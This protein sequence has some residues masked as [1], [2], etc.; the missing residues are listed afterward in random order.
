MDTTIIESLLSPW[1][2]VL[3]YMVILIVGSIAIRI[4]FTLDVNEWLKDRRS[5]KQL[6]NI[7]KAS[8]KCRHSWTLYHRSPISQCNSCLVAISTSILLI[9]RELADI[10]PLI[11][12]ESYD[13]VPK[14]PGGY[15]IT[16][17]Y[18]GGER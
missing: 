17:D 7:E 15:P 10:K 8:R 12:A 16:S 11:F 18:I 6:K 14:F 2:K 3:L 4:S 9:A 1:W 5:A 13:I